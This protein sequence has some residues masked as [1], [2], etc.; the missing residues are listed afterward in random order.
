MRA[1]T[2]LFY[3]IL[4]V[5]CCIL[6]QPLSAQVVINEY[7]VSNLNQFPDNYNNY[8]DWVEL[9]NTGSAA[10]QI[11]GFFLS[12]KLGNPQKWQFPPNTSIAAGG[13]LIIWTSGRNEVLAGHYHSNFK[14][15]QTK[16]NTEHIVLSDASGTIIQSIQLQNTQL[17]HSRGR[18][19][20]GSSIWSVYTSPTPGN[21]NNSATKYE[22]YAQKPNMNLQA[23]FYAGTIQVTISCS[24]PNSQVYYTTNGYLPTTSSTPNTVPVN[25]TATTVLKARTFS[26][27]PN[28]LP[29]LVEFNTYFINE[30]HTVPVI[31]VSANE[32]QALLNGN[33]VLKPHG[34]LEYFNTQG[35]RT[36][37]GYGEFNEHG[38]D[39]WVHPQRSIDYITR[40]EMGYNYAIQEKLLPLSD[41]T[42]FQRFI[43]RASGDDN[44]PGID[45][46]AH[47]R[48]NFIQNYAQHSGLNLDVRKGARIV[49]YANGTFWGIYSIREKVSDHDFTKYYY[50]QD[51][52]QIQ[53]LMY[54]G[55]LWAEYGGQEAI[56]EWFAFRNFILNNNVNDPQ[57]FAYIRENFDYTSLVDY[58]IINSFVVCSDWLNWNVGWWRGLNPDGGHRKWGYILWD[59]DATFGHYINYTGIPGQHPTVS[60]CFPENLPSYSDPQKHITILNKLRQNPEVE[61]YYISRYLDLK[62]TIFTKEPMLHFLD[63]MAAVIAPEMSRHVA[64]WGGTVTKWQNNVQKIR[65]FINARCDYLETGLMNCYTLTGPYD[66]TINVSEPGPGKVKLNS[67]LLN[68][69]PW[70]GQYYG[71]V[72]VKLTAEVVDNNYE[73]DYWELSNHNASPNINATTI[74]ISPSN[75][76]NVIAHFKLRPY[77][78]SLVINEINYKSSSTFDSEDWIEFYNPHD[79]PLDISNW[80]FKDDDDSHIYVFSINTI[81][82]SYGYVVLCRDTIKFKAR[83]PQVNNYL[84]NMDFGFSSD[85][86]LLRLYNNLDILIDTVHYGNSLPWPPQANGSGKTLELIHPGFDNALPESWKASPLHGS[87]G[88]MNRLAGDSNCDGNINLL[89]AITIVNYILGLNPQPFCFYNADVNNDGTINLNDLIGTI[90]IITGGG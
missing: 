86:E 2:I 87:P 9:Y 59:E 49:M 20:N 81:L 77:I 64:R 33:Q 71:G 61:Q 65:N 28:I 72:N 35:I 14:L 42:E 1:F 54:W 83:Y 84:G 41:R 58:V 5:L 26:N 57:V 56:N 25:I 60:P 68:E 16:S 29:S 69:Y 78:D 63:S 53:F 34:T 37:S 36:S 18:S 11:G 50:N 17:G 4:L 32:I 55:Y 79:Y 22:G 27:N 23:G 82:P 80:Y 47:M 75:W 43:L 52:Y 15:N 38:Q 8:E 24:E 46:S 66:F 39:S 45:S 74:F 85:G 19:T 62:N 67:L 73:F 76:E 88:L 30:T 6:N 3:S 40:D 31:S 90:N 13:F 89:D 12:D 70:T 51:K 7:S 10:A 44:F 21:S 48:D